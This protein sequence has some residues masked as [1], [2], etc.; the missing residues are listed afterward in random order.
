MPRDRLISFVRRSASGKSTM[1]VVCNFTPTVHY[2]VRLGV[3]VAGRYCERLNSDSRF[4]G[5]SDV[6]TGDVQSQPQGA[7]GHPHSVLV[8][9]PPLS[10]VFF[11][12]VTP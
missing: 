12:L 11:E 4:Y 10:T 8:N 2:E 5:G 9:I 3:P 7:H 1:L 6:G